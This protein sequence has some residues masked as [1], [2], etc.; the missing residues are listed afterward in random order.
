MLD[1]HVTAYLARIVTMTDDVTLTLETE[2]TRRLA[3]GASERFG[4]LLLRGADKQRRGVASPRRRER[5]EAANGRLATLVADA[6]AK[7]WLQSL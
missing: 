3:D 4:T 5:A 2:L 1:A 7:L 6:L